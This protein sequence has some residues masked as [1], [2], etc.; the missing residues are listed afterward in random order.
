M[1]RL[2]RTLMKPFTVP[3]AM[4]ARQVAAMDEPLKRHI[5]AYEARGEDITVAVWREYVDGQRALLPYRWAKLQSEVSYLASGEMAMTD[6]S[7]ADVVLFVRFLT[8]CVFIFIVA[9]MI[10]RRSVFPS[11]APTSP[12]VEE[13]VKNWQPNRLR[14]VAGA[15]FMAREQEAAA[16]DSAAHQAEATPAS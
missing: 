11:L 1:S 13:I 7:I 2:V 6:V 3:V 8:K 5:D 9:V 12:F 4:C 10:G 15:A 14:R 16:A